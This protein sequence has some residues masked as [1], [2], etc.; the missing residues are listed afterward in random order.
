MK[1]T[2]GEKDLLSII[3]ELGELGEPRWVMQTY[4]RAVK[5]A[6]K[7][8]AEA[9]KNFAPWEYGNLSDA[10][11]VTSRKVKGENISEGRMGVNSQAWFVKRG[12]SG[13]LSS[14]GKLTRPVAYAPTIEFGGKYVQA[15][16]FIRPAYHAKG[17]PEQLLPHVKK[18]LV[19][20]IKRRTKFLTPG[21]K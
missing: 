9:A 21:V 6:L 15:Q 16:P 11:T 8:V 13:K 4:A 17:R 2:G 5:L 10:I 20:A 14:T 12:E 7:P 1:V 18:T 3:G 19:R